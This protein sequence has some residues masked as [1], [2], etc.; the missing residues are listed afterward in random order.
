MTNPTEQNVQ[1]DLF[2]RPEERGQPVENED[3]P[4]AFHPLSTA[5]PKN[6]VAERAVP[7]E[8]ENPGGDAHD[9]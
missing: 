7:N 9:A 1:L 8:Q 2:G 6:P 5:E 3:R 4:P